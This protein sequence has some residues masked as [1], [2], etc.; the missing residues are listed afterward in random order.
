QG[1]LHDG[2]APA[3]PP[4]TASALPVGLPRLAVAASATLSAPLAAALPATL[5]GCAAAAVA[6]VGLAGILIGVRARARPVLR[7]AV[8]LE[9]GDVVAPGRALAPTARVA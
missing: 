9:A 7:A 8:R 3:L 4:R 2:A 1:A 6:V 5:P